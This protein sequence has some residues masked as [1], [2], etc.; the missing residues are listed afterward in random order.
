VAHRNN[1]EILKEAV[2]RTSEKR[3]SIAELQEWKE[4]VEALQNDTSIQVLWEKYRKEN[5]YADSHS[6][7]DVITTLSTI[8]QSINN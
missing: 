3:N 8:G 7:S 4:I 2:R 1:F 5:A 6:F